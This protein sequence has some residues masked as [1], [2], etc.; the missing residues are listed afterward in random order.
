MLCGRLRPRQALC[1]VQS[2]DPQVNKAEK[3]R[4]LAAVCN[5]LYVRLVT[6]RLPAA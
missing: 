4:R 5:V 3:Y 1:P 6:E 2:R